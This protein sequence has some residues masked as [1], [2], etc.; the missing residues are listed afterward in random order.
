MAAE[1][2]PGVLTSKGLA[3]LAKWQL[4]TASPVFTR[5]EIGAGS[6]GADEDPS[7][8]TSLKDQK[9]SVLINSKRQQGANTILLKCVFDNRTL[10]S[11]GFRVTEIGIFALD[12]SE[13][14]ILYSIAVS[15][16]E[17]VADYLTTY[18]GAYPSTLAFNYQIEVSNANNA[19][20]QAGSGAYV[21]TDDLSPVSLNFAYG[22]RSPG[23]SVDSR[24]PKVGPD[25]HGVYAM[26]Y[27]A[28]GMCYIT[29]YILYS[30]RTASFESTCGEGLLIGSI[31]DEGYAP[32]FGGIVLNAQDIKETGYAHPGALSGALVESVIIN[33]A[34]DIMLF[35]KDEVPADDDVTI[36]FSGWWYCN[37]WPESR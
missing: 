11:S 36:W 33:T 19:A 7:T 17:S 30:D 15:V 35:L 3:L 9:L 29:G 16:D 28:L 31:T 10:T 27:P 12:P 25:N 22:G 1:F 13:G 5:A 2:K 18:N 14:E 32:Y 26:Y 23:T 4:G 34:G 37:P 24:E 20:I 6:Y 21:F 8:R